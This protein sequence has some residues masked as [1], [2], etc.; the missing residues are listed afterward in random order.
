VGICES[1]VVHARRLWAEDK[2]EVPPGFDPLKTPQSLRILVPRLI[3]GQ[4]PAL[5]T[6]YQFV[7]SRSPTSDDGLEVPVATGV[8]APSC[9]LAL[10]TLETF[11][12]HS[13][14]R[15]VEKLFSA[16]TPR[17]SL[18]HVFLITAWSHKKEKADPS[19]WIWGPWPLEGS[20][21]G[22]ATFWRAMDT[23]WQLRLYRQQMSGEPLLGTYVS[24]AA[25]HY[26]DL[27]LEELSNP[28]VD[29]SMKKIYQAA[30]SP[31]ELRICSLVV[32]H[33]Q[34]EA[35]I[36]PFRVVEKPEATVEVAPDEIFEEKLE[37]QDDSSGDDEYVEA[38]DEPTED[39]FVRK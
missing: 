14:P 26:A 22:M 21:G 9:E 16:H 30:L 13:W 31:E 1:C 33:Q 3:E 4:D 19:N 20:M 32:S 29:L 12:M 25:R 27:C 36:A 18:C 39:G 15:F 10:K 34:D 17:G 2:A 7:C 38:E 28:K 35:E 11:G 5:S 8:D 24:E 6:S 37:A 23:V